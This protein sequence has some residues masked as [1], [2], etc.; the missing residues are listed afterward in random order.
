MALIIAITVWKRD[1]A[2]ERETA[3]EMPRVLLFYILLNQLVDERIETTGSCCEENAQANVYRS[4]H[5]LV[6]LAAKQL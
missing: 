3:R 1:D 5:A 4:K 6:A 2:Q